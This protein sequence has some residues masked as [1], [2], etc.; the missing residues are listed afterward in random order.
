VAYLRLV[1]SSGPALRVGTVRVDG[2]TLFAFANASGNKVL[3]WSAYTAAGQELG[4]GRG[5]PAGK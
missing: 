4:G 3:R 5:D 1:R 2:Y